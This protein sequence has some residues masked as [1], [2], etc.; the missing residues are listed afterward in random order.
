[1]AA[2]HEEFSFGNKTLASIYHTR[3]ASIKKALQSKYWNGDHWAT[4]ELGIL[5]SCCSNGVSDCC[6]TLCGGGKCRNTD[7]GS[8]G[9]W[10][11][12]QV[13]A[14]YFNVSSDI[15]VRYARTDNSLNRTWL[16]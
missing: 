7:V 1:M 2:L 16:V 4:N 10:T 6:Q 15:K 9:V 5:R 8:P 11:D 12:D 14:L 3:A 13:W